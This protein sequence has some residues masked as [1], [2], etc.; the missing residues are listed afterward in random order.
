MD[1]ER[2][3]FEMVRLYLRKYGRMGD[4]EAQSLYIKLDKYIERKFPETD[5]DEDDIG[6]CMRESAERL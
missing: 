4:K 2:K 6:V 1:C 5:E 3:H